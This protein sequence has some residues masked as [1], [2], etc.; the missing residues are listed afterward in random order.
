MEISK[1]K[2]K[3]LLVG[4]YGHLLL[5]GRFHYQMFRWNV[6]SHYLG[7][8]EFPQRSEEISEP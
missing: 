7:E 2:R 8:M 1:A 5:F 6:N 4:T 3:I